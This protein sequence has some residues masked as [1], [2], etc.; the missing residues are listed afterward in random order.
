MNIVSRRL[1]P[2][3]S[4]RSFIVPSSE[5]RAELSALGTIQLVHCGNVAL[6][7]SQLMKITMWI[8]VTIVSSVVGQ[9][10]A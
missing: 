4:R 7:R 1:A 8:I 2:N 5:R 9:R 6:G 3:G 10:I